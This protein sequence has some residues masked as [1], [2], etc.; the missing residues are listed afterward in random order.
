MHAPFRREL[1]F[2]VVGLG[3][4]GVYLLQLSI[5][6]SAPAENRVHALIAGCVCLGLST[7]LLVIGVFAYRGRE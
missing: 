6:N 1:S 3:G 7:V 2:A 4:F 5:G